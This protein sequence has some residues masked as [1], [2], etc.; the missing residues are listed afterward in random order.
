MGWYD[1]DARVLRALGALAKD[2]W[3]DD[4]DSRPSMINLVQGDTSLSAEDAPHFSP[5]SSADSQLWQLLLRSY[6]DEW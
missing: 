6:S 1:D 5:G 2:C 4:P 3:V